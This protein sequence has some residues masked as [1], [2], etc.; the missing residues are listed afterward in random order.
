[1]A[2]TEIK[3]EIKPQKSKKTEHQET[4]SESVAS[5]AATFVAG[6]FIITFVMQL[7]TIPSGSMQKTLLVGDYVFVDRLTPAARAGYSGPVV[8]YR[9][10]HRGDIIVFL[11]PSQPGLHLVKRVIGIPGDKIHL[12]QGV[13]YRNGERLNEPYVIHN[14]TYESVR[15]DFPSVELPP[16]FDSYAPEWPW[17]SEIHN[18]IH[19]EDLVVPPDSYFAMGDNREDSVDSRYWGFVPRSNIIGRPLFIFWSQDVPPSSETAPTIGERIG[20][21]FYAVRHFFDKTRWTRTFHIV[22]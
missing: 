13:V 16:G 2:K 9:D 1:M 6:L 8:P 14:G 4:P 7:F 12:R 21:F 11:K 10:V 3:T 19:G 17:P 15:D 22:R 5:F 20:N 18:Y